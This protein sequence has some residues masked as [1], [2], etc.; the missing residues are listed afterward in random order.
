MAG[1]EMGCFWD[2]AR[3]CL[4][5]GPA[6]RP[7]SGHAWAGLAGAAGSLEGLRL[8]SAPFCQGLRSNVLLSF[9]DTPEKDSFR[10]RST[11][12]NERPKRCGAA[13]AG[14]VSE[15]GGSSVSWPVTS[16][17]RT[18]RLPPG[19]G[20]DLGPGRVCTPMWTMLGSKTPLG[21]EAGPYL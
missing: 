13:W 6:A 5:P 4:C 8:R 7:G 9:D 12:L 3:C 18:G 16:M 1:R 21:G 17:V 10:A 2:T 20:V 14:L 19:Q 15:V 11:S